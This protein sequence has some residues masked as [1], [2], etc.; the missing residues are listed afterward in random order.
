[1]KSLMPL[2]L[3][4]VGVLTVQG[5]QKAADAPAGAAASGAEAPHFGEG[6]VPQFE[7]DRAWP[8]LPAAWTAGAA[9]SA[10]QGDENGH[11]WLLQRPGMYAADTPKSAIPPSLIEFDADGNFVQGFGGP[12]GAPAVGYTWPT[13]P[14]G[15]SIDSKGFIWVVGSWGEG[16]DGGRSVKPGEKPGNDS[17]V[18]K[19]DKTGKFILALGQPGQVGTNKTHV[20]KGA[21]TPVYHEKTNEVFVSD[22]YGNNRVI[23]FDA[24]TGA[25]KRMWGAYGRPPLDKADR[26]APA[27]L[28]AE[29]G[30]LTGNNQMV[31]LAERLQQFG[32]PVHDIKISHDGLVYVADR[33]NRRVQVFT[34]EGKFLQEKFLGLDQFGPFYARSVA[35]SPDPE[36]KF[37]YVGGSPGIHIL[38]R[39]T[40]ETLGE[41]SLGTGDQTH[42]PGHNIGTD[43]AGNVYLL[44][45]DSLGLDGKTPNSFGAYKL[46]FKGYTP[47]TP[48]CQ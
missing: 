31:R 15:F 8:K 34:P 44:K 42:P 2:G 1:M 13:N 25:F 10:V 30:E 12:G 32:N 9:V 18:L 26:P 21:T 7:Y 11:V 41:A 22:G 23:V 17:Q 4:M 19:F 38:N 20:L 40:L 16:V 14:H 43:K 28:E 29:V 48:C 3:L 24:D 37:L 5:C 36:Q 47:T 45:T 27:Q 39:R 6:G 46:T 35:F 33:P